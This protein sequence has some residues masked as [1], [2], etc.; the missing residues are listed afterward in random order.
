MRLLSMY[1]F[2]GYY[3][4]F[5]VECNYTLLQQYISKEGCEFGL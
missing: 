1:E 2:G 3:S 5:D 4:D